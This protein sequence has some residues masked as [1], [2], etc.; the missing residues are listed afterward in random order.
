M[1]VYSSNEYNLFQTIK[2]YSPKNLHFVIIYSPSSCSKPVCISFSCWTQ[3]WIFWTIWAKQLMGPI[4]FHS[5][6]KKNS[7][8]VNGA[9]W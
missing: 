3:K 2:G 7:M 1:C 5:M 9:K 4:D 6:G 8:E